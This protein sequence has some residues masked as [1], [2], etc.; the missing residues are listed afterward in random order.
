MCGLC[1]ALAGGRH[2]SD[3]AG[4]EGFEASD[5]Y[6]TRRGERQRRTALINRLLAPQGLTI[7]DWAGTSY[8][9]HSKRGA[10]AEVSTLPDL[11][12]AIERET[13]EAIDPLDPNLLAA[14]RRGLDG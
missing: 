3:G 10:V 4:R 12:L 7:E 9:L 13:G 2:W 1:G 5:K 11:W 14:A 6:R 8:V